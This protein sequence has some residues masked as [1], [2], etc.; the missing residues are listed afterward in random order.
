[1]TASETLHPELTADLVEQVLHL[2]PAARKSLGGLL[3]REEAD[4]AKYNRELWAEVRRRLD[5]YDRG[6]EVAHDW[7][8]VA[9]SIRAEMA[10]MREARST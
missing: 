8:D 2:S 5:A 1:M 6:E 4:E 3:E 10:S 9:A 7:R